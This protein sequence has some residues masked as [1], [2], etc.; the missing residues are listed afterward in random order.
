MKV[1]KD[2]EELLNRE[3]NFSNLRAKLAKIKP[4]CI[5]YLGMYLTDITFIE[6]GMADFLPLNPDFTWDPVTREKP[7]PSGLINFGKRRLLAKTTGEIGFYQNSPYVINPDPN[8][9]QYLMA[10][11]SRATHAIDIT[12]AA[13]S[14]ADRKALEDKFY[15]Q[16]IKIE[17]RNIDDKAR[18]PIGVAFFQGLQGGAGE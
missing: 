12:N 1:L 5:P 10:F 15:A 2:C 14:N 16:S 4:P 11:P 9:V 6:E 8:I 17:P 3:R 18:L 7:R 13:P